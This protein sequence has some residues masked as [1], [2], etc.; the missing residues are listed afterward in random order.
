MIGLI[1]QSK[2]CGLGGLDHILGWLIPHLTLYNACDGSHTGVVT[3]DGSAL[4]NGVRR[5]I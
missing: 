4:L 3:L 1:L 2:M 5:T